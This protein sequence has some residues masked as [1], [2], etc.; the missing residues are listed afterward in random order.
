MCF[1]YRSL[2]VTLSNASSTPVLRPKYVASICITPPPL[3]TGCIHWNL[4]V[5]NRRFTVEGLSP[6]FSLIWATVCLPCRYISQ[7]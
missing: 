1:I 2:P 6:V 7:M 5:A 3:T 4:M